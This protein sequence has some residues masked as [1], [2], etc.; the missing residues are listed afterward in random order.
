MQKKLEIRQTLLNEETKQP[1][2]AQHNGVRLARHNRQDT[3]GRDWGT[4]FDAT[5]LERE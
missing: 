2:V 5:Q 3:I 4:R 1:G